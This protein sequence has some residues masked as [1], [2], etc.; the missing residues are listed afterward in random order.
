MP[1]RPQP[2]IIPSPGFRRKESLVEGKVDLSGLFYYLGEKKK[3]KEDEEQLLALAKLLFPPKPERLLEG[4]PAR[5][6]AEGTPTRPGEPDFIQP[7]MQPFRTPVLPPSREEM[8]TT[9]FL[10]EQKS[11]LADWLLPEAGKGEERT[12]FQKELPMLGEGERG[13]ALLQHFGIA[14]KEPKEREPLDD[15]I[16]DSMA[17]EV[18]LPK[19]Q[20]GSISFNQAAK[21]GYVKKDKLEKMSLAWTAGSNLRKEFLDHPVTKTFYLVEGQYGNVEETFNL[22]KQ[23]TED[24]KRKGVSPNYSVV[25]D[26]LLVLIAKLEDPTSVAREGE[27]IRY[28]GGRSVLGG[29][30]SAAQ[31]VV[32]G[33][34]LTDSDRREILKLATSFLGGAKERYSNIADYYGGLAVDLGVPKKHVV[35]PPGIRP[36]NLDEE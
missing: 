29:L 25:D 22:Y 17:E 12:A 27:V 18:G 6:G 20:I 9:R 26:A 33:G 34:R 32:K 10:R 21:L 31:R 3:K 35:V 5:L 23:I 15:P 28:L 1:S 30:H 16:P 24:A 13:A 14:P 8:E 7:Q 19:D 11:A 36:L 4:E 2:I